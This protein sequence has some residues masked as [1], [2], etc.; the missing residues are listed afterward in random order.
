MEEEEVQATSM[1]A[2]GS[3]VRFAVDSADKCGN[4]VVGGGIEVD[5]ACACEG[6]GDGGIGCA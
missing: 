4:W 1:G 5:G 6:V 3:M 2:S